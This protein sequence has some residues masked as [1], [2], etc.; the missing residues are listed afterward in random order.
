LTQWIACCTCGLQ[1]P[2]ELQQTT[3]NLNLCLRCGKR[4]REGRQGSFTQFIFRY[5]L[6]DCDVPES[7]KPTVVETAPAVEDVVEEDE[8]ELPID[9]KHFPVDRYKP[10]ELV[11]KGSAGTAYFCRDRLLNKKVILKALHVFSDA[12]LVAFDREAKTM[13]KLDHPGI[14]HVLDFGATEG[15]TPYMVLDYTAGASLEYHIKALGGLPWKLVEPIFLSLTEALAYCHSQKVFHR[16]LKPSNIIVVLAE[17]P[18]VKLIDFGVALIS[19]QDPASAAQQGKTVVGTPAYMSPDQARGEG[20]DERGE[21]YSLGCVLFE[22]LT[23]VPP[24]SGET[25]LVVLNQHVNE[26]PPLLSDYVAYELPPHVQSI[27][28]RC[29]EKNKHARFQ[30]ME[31]LH[32]ALLNQ[33]LQLESTPPPQI[34]SRQNENAKLATIVAAV[35]IGL[36][37][38]G[39]GLFTFISKEPDQ[40]TPPAQTAPVVAKRVEDEPFVGRELNER[41]AAA[42]FSYKIRAKTS[43][44]MK[45]DITAD[46]VRS[47]LKKF[48]VGQISFGHNSD[49]SLT[50]MDW[51]ALELFKNS[52]ITWL[53]L[54]NTD[55][56]D[57]G[58]QYIESFP[59]LRA[60]VL[61]ETKLTPEGFRRLCD[62]KAIRNIDD[63]SLDR[64]ELL[65]GSSLK[66]LGKL[67]K[68]EDVRFR[69]MTGVT[70]DT[71][72]VFHE[73]PALKLLTM[74]NT[75]IGDEGLAVLK[76]L[77][78]KRLNIDGC[79]ITDAGLKYL[80][81]FPQ[82]ESVT[83]DDNPGITDSGIRDLADTKTLKGIWCK[84]NPQ[85]KDTVKFLEQKKLLGKQSR[86]ASGSM[87]NQWMRETDAEKLRSV[88]QLP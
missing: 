82:L 74:D 43:L 34:E 14:A 76:G 15:G 60:I 22:C 19:A 52:K 41:E 78:V 72:K 38:L 13:S 35:V 46:D 21:I 5:D 70:P 71:L 61:N 67:K 86:P 73:L 17:P 2:A 84:R 23:G 88:E 87:L 69:N 8:E 39:I 32:S 54:E 85:L 47:V 80:K 48:T 9:P 51:S 79:Q 20:Y 1:A 25:A 27:V 36:V 66:H 49:F 12:D 37:A 68:L 83:L 56:D 42:Q 29:L 28:S 62:M 44:S 24:F 10:L 65:T 16:D 3:T 31:Q 59:H 57:S 30:S 58:V 50:H 53:D 11:G 64:M 26:E 63:I 4:I 75:N 7:L 40:K 6:C 77:G 81:T 55:F 33:T 18:L 45:G